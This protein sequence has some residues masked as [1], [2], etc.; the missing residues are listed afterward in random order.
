MFAHNAAKASTTGR[1]RGVRQGLAL[2]LA[3][4]M[5]AVAA[6][7]A[8]FQGDIG[9]MLTHSASPAAGVASPNAALPYVYGD[10]GRFY[11]RVDTFGVRTLPWGQGHLEAAVRVSTEGWSAADSAHPRA[12]DRAAPLPI[13]L[14]TFQR[15]A[16]GG[17]FGYLMHDPRSGGQ[18]AE[19]TWA[20]RT[21]LGPVQVF[22][23]LGLQYRSADYVNHLY[24]LNAAQAA[25]T[26]LAPYRA[27]ASLLPQLSVHATV[28]LS[29]PWALQLQARHRWLDGAIAHSPLM[30]RASQNSALIALTYSL[31]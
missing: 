22:P 6:Q 15:T 7:D 25:A 14:G 21:T 24:G 3:C 30:D 16:L 19:L 8:R 20:L 4:S 29:G 18:F 28:P 27:G 23:Q 5:G 2:A 9:G 17:F 1:A 26:G 11:G 13:G 10:W 12:G 31:P